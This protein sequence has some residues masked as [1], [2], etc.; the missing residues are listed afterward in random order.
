MPFEGGTAQGQT[1]TLGTGAFIPGFEEQMVGMTVGEEKDLN[2]TF[3]EKYHAEELAGKTAVFHVKVNSVTKT[4]LPEL[5]D[6]FAQDVNELRHLRRITRTACRQEAA[7][8]CRHELRCRN[9]EC[10]D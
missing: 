1:L 6:E 10:A 9:R 3:P 2:V 7:R 5:D 8:E 4:E